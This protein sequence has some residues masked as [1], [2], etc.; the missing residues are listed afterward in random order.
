MQRDRVPSCGIGNGEDLLGK[1]RVGSGMEKVG[2]CLYRS[3]DS[4][5]KGIA[6]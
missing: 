5:M 4:G 3:V 1:F 6:G 2:C